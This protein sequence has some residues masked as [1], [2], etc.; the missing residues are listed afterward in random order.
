MLPAFAPYTSPN[1]YPS[2]D[3]SMGQEEALKLLHEYRLTGKEAPRNKILM[4]NMRRIL[5]L[6]KR[7]EFQVADIPH[8]DILQE[9]IIGFMKGI[10]KYDE[11]KAITVRGTASISTHA[12]RWAEK[13]IKLHIQQCGHSVRVPDNCERAYKVMMVKYEE[14]RREHETDY[15]APDALIGGEI[16]KEKGGKSKPF[17]PYQIAG[18]LTIHTRSYADPNAT[19]IA[20]EAD[21]HHHS[22]DVQ[23][24]M[25]AADRLPEPQRG[26]FRAYYGLGDIEL[27][28]LMKQKRYSQA[29]VE[30]IVAGCITKIRR[31]LSYNEANRSTVPTPRERVFVKAEQLSITFKAP[32][33]R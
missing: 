4:G 14:A 11:A 9:A 28:K 8:E 15:I 31:A 6:C 5:G 19:P 27:K 29:D 18:A 20:A 30:K 12:Y 33:S 1:H 32:R 16:P 22:K 25:E 2:E 13:F 26:I 21:Y 10:D 7:P 23:H 24:V 17:H 3:I